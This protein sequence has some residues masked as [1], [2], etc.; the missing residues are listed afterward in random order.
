MFRA[1]IFIVIHKMLEK[2]NMLEYN[3]KEF[4][5]QNKGRK[6]LMRNLNCKNKN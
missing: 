6:N 2:Y 1:Y 5:F 4:E 3:K